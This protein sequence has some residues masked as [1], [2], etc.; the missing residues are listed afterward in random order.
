MISGTLKFI[1]GNSGVEE[2]I[3]RIL[4]IV[5]SQYSPEVLRDNSMLGEVFSKIS[6]KIFLIDFHIF[7][8]FKKCITNQFFGEISTQHFR[9][10]SSIKS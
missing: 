1:F 5:I 3:F 2:F 10:Q 7:L 6:Q 8:F 4:W 9:L